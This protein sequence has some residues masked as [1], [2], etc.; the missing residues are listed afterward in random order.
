MDTA[1]RGRSDEV[2]SGSAG[3]SFMG[4]LDRAFSNFVD[5]RLGRGGVEQRALAV[6]AVR[7][8]SPPG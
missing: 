5:R 2:Y 6:P 1:I 8:A 3:W 7:L 4:T